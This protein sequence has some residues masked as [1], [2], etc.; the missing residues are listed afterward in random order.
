LRKEAEEDKRRRNDDLRREA[1][2]DRRRRDDELR[3]EAERRKD[4]ILI[5][6]KEAQPAIP[7][8]ITI[9]NSKLP[10]MKEG[11]LIEMFIAMFEA[12]L[13]AGNIPVDQWCSKLHAHLDPGAKLKVKNVI[14]ADDAT[15]DA[16]KEA[17]LG[18]MG[19]SF[20]ATAETLMTADRGR[21]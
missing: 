3:R 12:A 5:A 14:E 13:R 9:I 21:L 10:K 18:C 6:L 19:W 1:E 16:I 2:E 20:S 4:R 15:Y 17:L 8:N 7:Q 11:E